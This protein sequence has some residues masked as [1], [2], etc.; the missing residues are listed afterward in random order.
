MIYFYPLTTLKL[1]VYG[2][3]KICQKKFQISLKLAWS[4]LCHRCAKVIDLLKKILFSQ[5]FIAK[6]KIA[7]QDFTR[8][9]KLPFHLLICFLLNLIKGSYQSELDRFF[10][11]MTRSNIAKRFVSKAALTKARMKLKA[12]AFVEL[13]DHLIDCFDAN[14]QPITW[15]GFRLVGADGSTVKLPK[16]NEIIDHFGVWNVLHGDPCPMA[17]I[18]QL[19]DPLNKMTINALIGPK[20]TGER[21]QAA[22]LFSTLPFNALILL[23]RGYPAFWLFKLIA[24]QRAQFCARVSRKWDI[25]RK[26]INSGKKEKRIVLKAAYSSIEQCRELG[27]DIAP[28]TFRLIRVELDSGETEVLITS[29]TDKQTYPKDIFAELYHKRWPVEEDYKI[30][31]RR[32]E[33]EAFTGKSVL[34]IYQDFYASIFFKN[35]VSLMA[36]P[37]QSEIKA[38][39]KK[40]LYEHQINFTYALGKAKHLVVLL[41]QRTIAVTRQLVRNFQWLLLNTTEPIRPGRKYPRKHKVVKKSFYLN[42]KPVC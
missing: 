18:S 38:S 21:R 19:F 33:I 34:S 24:S 15:H 9:R 35:L 5:E 23:D 28:L 13:N 16:T 36:H 31:K 3:R 32:I 11:T 37:V 39:G 26:F 25:V 8:N 12:E 1:L 4:L 30:M 40:E 29:L 42:Y 14:F 7:D 41:F 10:Q 22:Q 2:R 27:L 20:S 17:R 6:H